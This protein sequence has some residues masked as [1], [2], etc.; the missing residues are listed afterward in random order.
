MFVGVVEG[1]MQWTLQLQNTT[2]K[3]EVG[4]RIEPEMPSDSRNCTDSGDIECSVIESPLNN[5]CR[6]MVGF[7]TTSMHFMR[8]TL[9]VH[10][11]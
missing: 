8:A 6:Q 11:Q 9:V 4:P 7:G 2:S 3:L 5:A 1:N 10:W